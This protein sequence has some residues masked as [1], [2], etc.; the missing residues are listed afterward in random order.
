MPL[1]TLK[2]LEKTHKNYPEM[3]VI[4]VTPDNFE[5]IQKTVRYLKAQTVRDQLEIVIVAPSKD[6]LGIKISDLKDFLQFR[7]IEAGVVSSIAK[8]Y[9]IGIRHAR[10]P[11]VALAEDHSFPDS[12][13]AEALIKAHRQSWAAV[14]PAIRNANPYNLVSWADLLIAYAPWLVPAEAGMID[15]LPGHNSSYK[16]SI[17]LEYE[18]KLESMLEL[19]SILHWD[20]KAKGYKLYLEPEAKTSHLN[21]ERLSSWLPAQFYNG[22][23]FA[24]ARSRNWFMLHRLLY[25]TGSPL[26]PLIRVSHILRNFRRDNNKRNLLLKIFPI[27]ILGLLVSAFGEMIGYALGTGNSRQKM[28][29]FEFHRTR[30]LKNKERYEYG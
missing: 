17:L 27:L 4:M 30:H 21:F 14:G 12:G 16:R 2:N 19:E 20:L 5:T 13:W 11:L 23:L 28:S 9:A 29:K 3:S 24:S 7:V 18:S 1:D 22:R 26:V 8:A 10:A 6:N 15:H 25:T